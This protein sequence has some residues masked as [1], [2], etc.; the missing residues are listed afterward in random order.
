MDLPALSFLL[1]KLR[2]TLQSFLSCLLL[3]FAFGCNYV[4]VMSTMWKRVT[5]ICVS[6]L[7]S[8]KEPLA[9]TVCK[10]T[11]YNLHRSKLQ[12]PTIDRMFEDRHVTERRKVYLPLPTNDCRKG[13]KKHSLFFWWVL[14]FDFF[15]EENT[16]FTPFFTHWLPV[17]SLD[18][19]IFCPCYVSSCSS[20]CCSLFPDI[21]SE[22]VRQEEA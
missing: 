20:C 11:A 2:F 21:A 16:R 6:L 14:S 18:V 7:S 19:L 3:V 1:E 13:I 17:L 4:V 15:A 5:W 8:L 10:Y 9:L 22:A 12:T